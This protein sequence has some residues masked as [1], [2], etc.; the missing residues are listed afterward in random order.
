MPT[1]MINVDQVI[2]KTAYGTT[3]CLD[4]IREV[5]LEQEQDYPDYLFNNNSVICANRINCKITVKN[6][7]NYKSKRYRKNRKGYRGLCD[8][9]ER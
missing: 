6:D 9:L 7:R 3:V 1:R 8:L 5:E 2:I 4:G